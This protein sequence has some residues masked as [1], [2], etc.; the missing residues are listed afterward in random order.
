MFTKK[1]VKLINN[2]VKSARI[3]TWPRVWGEMIVAAVLA[4][5]PHF[6]MFT[7]IKGFIAVSP[8]LWTAGYTLNDL[9]DIRLDIKHEVRKDRPVTK[10]DLP[11]K[12]A[13]V[14]ILIFVILSIAI[15]IS[16]SP[17]FSFLL[18]CLF[19]S[20]IL[21]TLPPLRLK[22]KVF[23]D[24]FLNGVN[25]ALRYFLGW[26]TQVGIH[27][28]SL[29]PLIM[30]VTI[31]LIFY[32]GHR[33]QNKKLE[34]ENNIKSTTSIFSV[35]KT[36]L[37]MVI[38]FSLSCISYIIALL[39]N[40]FPPVSLIAP[41][42]GFL[43]LLVYFLKNNHKIIFSQEKNLSFRNTLYVSYFLFMNL[44]AVSLLVGF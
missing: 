25:S 12:D 30:L 5:Y 3:N 43:P 16:I 39:L 36:G 7:F 26:L 9:T 11:K 20:Q 4:S 22:E 40:I 42:I 37:L 18:L 8:L 35:R 15:G 44:L 38:L 21:Y 34:E 32:M 24:I 31:K 6:D 13:V 14:L 29:Y 17:L 23:W 41:L 33:F 28:F 10:G 2:T 19:F 27:P 1:A